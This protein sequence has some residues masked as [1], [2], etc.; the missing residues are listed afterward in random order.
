MRQNVLRCADNRRELLQLGSERLASVTQLHLGSRIGELPGIDIT[1][2]YR[3]FDFIEAYILVL[4]DIVAN[5]VGQLGHESAYNEV[6]ISG[7]D[8][9]ITKFL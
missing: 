8:P 9:V 6:R 5:I 7:A 4:L 3:N 2:G 1:S